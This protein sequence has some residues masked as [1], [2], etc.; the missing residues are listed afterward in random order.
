MKSRL[1]EHMDGQWRA[2][3]VGMMALFFGVLLFA[4]MLEL[5]KRG[6]LRALAVMPGS[7]LTWWVVVEAWRGFRRHG[8]EV[9]R[10]R[11]WQPDE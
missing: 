6:D 5:A 7:V 10:L 8:A 3:S 11:E 2:F 4:V 9:E 1:E